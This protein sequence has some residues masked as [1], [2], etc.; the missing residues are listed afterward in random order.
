M[1]LVLN[2]ESQ[3]FLIRGQ[4]VMLDTHLAALYDV[5]TKRLN[6]QVRRNIRRFP[7]DFMFQL[8]DAE[9]QNLRSQMATSSSGYGGRRYLPF[10]FTEQGIAMLSS[11][12]NSERAIQVNITIMRV[13]A[14]LRELMV[15][16]EDLAAKLK[17]LE[18]R[19]DTQD[20]KILAIF[21]AIGELVNPKKSRLKIGF[22]PTV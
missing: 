13:F 10:A 22:K 3:L 15:R 18:T 2:V 9:A 1:D 19:V 14:K 6:E 21:N 7:D 4:R 17:E 8:T 16:R 12:L 5:P 20:T 11:V